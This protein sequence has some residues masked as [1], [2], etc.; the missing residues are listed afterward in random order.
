M[1]SIYIQLFTICTLFINCKGQNS[2]SVETVSV[3]F[4]TEKMKL[5][6][7]PQL[8]DVRTPE[9]F[10]AEHIENAVNINWNGDDFTTQSEKL[11]KSKPVFVYCKVGGR[12]AQAATKLSQMGF[13]KIYNLD[14]GIMKWNAEGISKPSSEKVGMSKADFDKI[15]ISD[16]KVLID[17]YAKW[18]GPCKKMSPYLEKM[19]IELKDKITIVKIDADEH[20]SICEELKIEGLPTLMLYDKGELSWT[21]VG[22]I[23]ETDLRKKL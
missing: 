12:S 5:A 20:K 6:K 7:N 15:V 9:E 18:C 19:K 10:N 4:F 23:S 1:K 3:K 17:F 22:F 11:D 13:D 21:N 8:I 14:G 16:K 2:E